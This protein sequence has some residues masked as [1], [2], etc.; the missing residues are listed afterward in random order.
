MTSRKFFGIDLFCGCGGVTNGLLRAGVDVRLGIDFEESYRATYENNNKVPFLARDI[1]KVSALDILPFVRDVGSGH[2]VIS[3]CAPCQP[4]SLKNG[5]RSH[6]SSVDPRVDLSFELLRIVSE[7]EHEG[8]IC[9]GIFIENVPEFSKSPVW[10]GVK[11]ELLRKGF[12]VAYKV[13]NCA[14]YGVPQ[15]RRRFIAFAVRGW[16]FLGMPTPTHG[17]GRLPHRTVREA[18]SGLPKIG[19]GQECKLTPNHRARAL[20][21]V[22]LQRISSV[23]LNGGSRSSFPE[24]L[25]LEC[26]KRFDG[27]HDVYG[28]M[29]LDLP[30]PTITTKCISI[31][32]G[33]YGHPLEN[34]AISVREAARLQTFPDDF[35][36]FG[37]SIE[38]DSRMIGNAVPVAIAELFGRTIVSRISQL[39]AVDSLNR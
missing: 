39:E 12:S 1:R 31:T 13:I 24:E 14:D 32:N 4:F 20:S 36:F 3:S 10:Q 37:T 27:H 28:R 21:Q 5:K 11:H 35:H 30:S 34:R 8:I 25:V 22:N 6:D 38:T 16:C 7:L 15:N 26:H 2:F 29:S 9:S 33:R 18:F 17:E 23:P 19:A